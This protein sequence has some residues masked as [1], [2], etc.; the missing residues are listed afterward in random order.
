MKKGYLL[1]GSTLWQPWSLSVIAIETFLVHASG[2]LAFTIV[3]A[4][5]TNAKAIIP[6]NTV[7]LIF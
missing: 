6:A 1:F 3:A 2:H 4:K 5:R 7:R